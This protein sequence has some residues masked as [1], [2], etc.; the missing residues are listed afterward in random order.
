MA[1][2]DFQ[3]RLPFEW[4]AWETP[5]LRSGA[6]H[7]F[8][9]FWLRSLWRNLPQKYHML[10]AKAPFYGTI[11]KWQKLRRGGEHCRKLRTNPERGFGISHFDFQAPWGKQASFLRASTIKMYCHQLDQVPKPSFTGAFRGAIFYRPHISALC[12]QP[13]SQVTMATGMLKWLS[14][15]LK[16]CFSFPCHHVDH[17]KRGVS[18]KLVTELWT[19]L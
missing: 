6:L 11:Q 1:W 8:L 5:S 13:A 18:S 4:V 17:P 12:Q 19:G 15:D 2:G 9:V 7:L 16:I 14:W 10:K 3:K